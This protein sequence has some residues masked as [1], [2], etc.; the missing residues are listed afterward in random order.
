M[1]VAVPAVTAAA[2]DVA[3]GDHLGIEREHFRMA[4]AGAEGV[5]GA[6]GE[7]VHI[8][9]VER[10]RIDRR[11]HVLGQHAAERGGKRHASPAPAA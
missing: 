7:A 1:V 8:G 9:A 3:A 5:G 6:H 10:R 4:I 11:H 2:G